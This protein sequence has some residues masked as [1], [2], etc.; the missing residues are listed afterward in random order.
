MHICTVGVMLLSLIGVFSFGESKAS[1][2]YSTGWS[3]FHSEDGK[4]E[5]IITTSTYDRNVR[6]FVRGLWQAS[7]D[8]SPYITGYADQLRVRLCNISTGACTSYSRLINGGFEAGH[9]VWY[10]WFTG[11]KVGKFYVDIS[12]IMPGRYMIGQR[13]ILVR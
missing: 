12:D 13:N 6:I 10:V 9:E 2:D 4:D 1:A 7:I 8:G 5:G 3:S 11:M